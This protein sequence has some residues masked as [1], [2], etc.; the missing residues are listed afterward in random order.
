MQNKVIYICSVQHTGTWF[1]IEFL[2]RHSRIREVLFQWRDVRICNAFPK[3][4]PNIWDMVHTHCGTC[5]H[6]QTDM[7]E[8]DDTLDMKCMM[9]M[10]ADM[11]IKTMP[12]V[13][14]VRDPLR[15]IITRQIRH[16]EKTHNYIVNGFIYMA[17]VWER[18]D[19]MSP[20][21]FLTVDLHIE[22]SLSERIKAL[23]SVLHTVGLDEEPYVTEYA[24]KWEAPKFNITPDVP[25]KNWCK[26]GEMEKVKAEL[27]IEWEYLQSKEQHIRPFLE[28]LGY[29]SLIW[30]S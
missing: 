9:P 4:E 25:L 6:H 7:S 17:Q 24:K 1:V 22:R 12:T 20:V 30:Y 28:S 27:P 10:M 11:W 13:M 23:N 5:W 21:N 16:P 8:Y 19:E 3:L 29:E 15:A 14:P 2:K 18:M 26:A